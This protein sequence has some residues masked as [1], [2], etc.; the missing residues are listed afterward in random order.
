MK[1]TI[2]KVNKWARLS[3]PKW[4]K[5]PTARNVCRSM[6]QAVVLSANRMPEMKE[7]SEKSLAGE[8]WCNSYPWPYRHPD[9]ADWPEEYGSANSLVLDFCGFIVKHDTS[10][11]AWKI[12]EATGWW[13]EKTLLLKFSDLDF[14]RYLS[15]SGYDELAQKPSPGNKFVGIYPAEKDECLVVWYETTEK[16][17][18]PHPNKNVVVST[19]FNKEYK[20]YLVDPDKITWIKIK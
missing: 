1:I 11:I 2:S 6:Y 16:P 15:A 17:E 9:F 4:C 10:Y 13:P 3:C 7:L 18:P 8:Y 20:I 12:Y 14:I 5:N 19:Y